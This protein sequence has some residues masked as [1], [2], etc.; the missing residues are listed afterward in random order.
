VGIR[1]ASAWST[2]RFDGEAL[3]R[4]G[5]RTPTES[6]EPP[7]RGLALSRAALSMIDAVE[8]IDLAGGPAG[9]GFIAGRKLV[10]PREWFFE[11]HFYQ[12]P[13]MPGSLGLEALLELMKV[14]ARARFPELVETHRFESMA[15]G[16]AHRWQ[17]RG[18]VIPTNEEV[19]VEARATSVDVS[20]RLLVFDG[21]LLVDGKIIYGMK[22][23]AL[24]L[25]PEG[26]TP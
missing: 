25:V 22:D 4:R 21:Q 17:Y 1:G 11:A 3:P 23:F 14:F 13:V 7:E 12:D 10:D 19:R 5:S 8:E 18:Q 6:R 2:K 24:R 16:R 9:V 26:G 15:L 20:A